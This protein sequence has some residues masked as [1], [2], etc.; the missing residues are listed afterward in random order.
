MTLLHYVW[1]ARRK[2]ERSPMSRNV[3]SCM[4]CTGHGNDFRLIPMV[5]TESQ[6]SVGWPTCHHFPRFLI[7]S[8]KSRSEVGSRW[9]WSCTVWGFWKK[10]PLQA[11]FHQRFPKGFM[12]KWKHVL[13]ANFVKFGWPEISKLVRYL[14][15]KKKQNL[16]WLSRFRFCAITPKICQGQLQTIYSEY[17]K[18]HPNPYTSGGVIAGSV[19]IVETSHKVFPI[20][21]EATRRRSASPSNKCTTFLTPFLWTNLT[22]QFSIIAYYWFSTKLSNIFSPTELILLATIQLDCKTY[23]IYIFILPHTYGFSSHYW[24]CVASYLSCVWQNN[25]H[26]NLHHHSQHHHYP[27]PTTIHKNQHK[28]YT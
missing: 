22:T 27:V 17:P 18:F 25:H 16:C 9:R 1:S 3:A 6:H 8:E 7:I 13:C 26:L 23:T 14:P 28:C 2:S 15:D 21:G 10:D 12:R 4:R 5:Q 19:N 11:N 20:L 24:F